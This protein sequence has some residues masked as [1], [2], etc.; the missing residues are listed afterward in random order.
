MKLYHHFA[1]VGVIYDPFQGR[2]YQFECKVCGMRY[3]VPVE[4][5]W[6]RVW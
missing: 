5:F 1:L 3:N 2:K 4:R 6:G